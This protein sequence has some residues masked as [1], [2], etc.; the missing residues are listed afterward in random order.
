MQSTATYREQGRAYLEQ[1]FVEFEAGD[2]SQASEKGWAAA[3][4]MLRAVAEERGWEHDSQQQLFGIVCSLASE[5]QREEL[6]DGLGA[7]ILL[8]TIFSEG[9]LDRALIKW[10]LGDVQEFVDS[11]ESLL[12]TR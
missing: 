2:L 12:K 4:Q 1:A 6:L 7:A 11:T 8:L 9:W 3:A 10:S 5:E